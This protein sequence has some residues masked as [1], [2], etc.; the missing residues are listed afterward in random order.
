MKRLM[1]SLLFL[2]M[3]AALAYFVMDKYY[4]EGLVVVK[5][6]WQ[7]A[8]QKIQDS[9]DDDS[10]IA[11][12][13]TNLESDLAAVIKNS[14]TDQGIAV[15][16]EVINGTEYID[17]L[18]LTGNGDESA[19]VQVSKDGLPTSLEV[20]DHLVLFDNFTNETV[21]ITVRLP[22]GSFEYFPQERINWPQQA[23]AWLPIRAA[24]AEDF[25]IDL[26]QPSGTRKDGNLTEYLTSA[27]GTAL[28]IIGCTAALVSLLPSFGT[29]GPLAWISCGVLAVRV[30]TTPTNI[31]GC[32]GDI[33]RC[34]TTAVKDLVVNEFVAGIEEAIDVGLEDANLF[35][36]DQDQVS[37][38]EDDEDLL[39]TLLFGD[40]EDDLAI[41][42]VNDGEYTATFKR[43]DVNEQGLTEVD[44]GMLTASFSGTSGIC[45][46]NADSSVTGSPQAPPGSPPGTVLPSVSI[47]SEAIST[48]CNGTLD[49]E[50][51]NFE[52]EGAVRTDLK[53][54]T[55]QLGEVATSGVGAFH[56]LG[57]IVDKKMVGTIFFS[58]KAIELVPYEQEQ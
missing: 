55:G 52:L 28:N 24:Q 34:G 50:T 16:T 14:G 56:V 36:E 41:P 8:E 6:A 47:S 1:L 40:E 33:I 23:A 25:R 10:M 9:S 46:L 27:P 58:N 30:I 39:D 31:A 21:D 12:I 51:G 5:E 20:D 45:V 35:D 32:E 3:L 15:F 18:V 17:Q 7:L 37:E 42:T 49:E 13:N 11:V 53:A 44:D 48:F 26:P 43:V 19:L 4:P 2:V 22:D 57:S 54:K 29:S 38:E